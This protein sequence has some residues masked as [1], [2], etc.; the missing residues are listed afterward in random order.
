MEGLLSGIV[1]FSLGVYFAEP[2]RE[3]VPLLDPNKGDKDGS[4]L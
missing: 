3:A 1:L 2:V 4:N